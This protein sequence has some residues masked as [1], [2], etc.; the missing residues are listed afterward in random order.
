MG[1][2]IV[3]CNKEEI[4]H[5]FLQAYREGLY[6]PKL[7]SEQI[8]FKAVVNGEIKG[9]AKNII[10]QNTVRLANLY[11]IPEYRG[12]GIA[13]ELIS[14]QIKHNGS[15][16]YDTYTCVPKIYNDF[17]FVVQSEKKIKSGTIYYMVKNV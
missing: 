9:F 12:L 4:S 6:F 17:G 1:K 8:Y 13:K 11:V 7:K 10:L 3:V 5:L 2:E 16:K 14:Y 15:L